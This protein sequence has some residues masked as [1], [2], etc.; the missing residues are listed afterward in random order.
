MVARH[1]MPRWPLVLPLMAATLVACSG[2]ADTPEPASTS[3]AV[4]D[5]AQILLPRTA[6][7]EGAIVRVVTMANP[8]DDGQHIL[9]QYPGFT[10]QA[11]ALSSTA[12]HR[13]ACEPHQS[14]STIRTET[15]GDVRTTISVSTKQGDETATSEQDA[16]VRF[17]EAAPLT[18][19]PEW[20]PAYSEDN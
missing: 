13:D 11:C 15:A 16:I 19:G 4:A 8:A 14:A 7:P 10:I 6:P 20:L 3:P 5:Y 17:F 12:K 1:S 2:K 9:L 18:N